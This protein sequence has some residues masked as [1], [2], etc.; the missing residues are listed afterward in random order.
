MMRIITTVGTSLFENYQSNNKNDYDFKDCYQEFKDKSDNFQILLNSDSDSEYQ[1]D[2]E[3]LLKPIKSWFLNQKDAS[4][5]IAS[6]LAIAGSETDIHVHLI[7]TDTVLSVL[8]AELIRDWLNES[9]YNITSYFT[10]PEKLKTQADSK[11]IIHQLRVSS[12]KDFQEGFMNL[13]EVTS[14]LIDE[15]KEDKEEVVLNITGGY[16]AII[17][18]MTLIG[19]IKKVPLKYIYEE[20]DLNKKTELVEVGNLPMNFDWAV[21]EGLR[22]YLS[23]TI[24]VDS[25]GSRSQTVI[26]QLTRLHLIKKELNDYKVTS[27]GNLLVDAFHNSA[28]DNRILGT[29]VEYKYLEYFIRIDNGTNCSVADYELEYTYKYDIDKETFVFDFE[30]DK[31]TLK[32]KAGDID[33]FLPKSKTIIEAKNFFT[34][35]KYLNSQG[36]YKIEKKDKVTED[37]YKQLKAKI[38]AFHFKEKKYPARVLFLV[39]AILFEK[40]NKDY[41]KDKDL[42]SSLSYFKRKLEQDYC[43]DEKPVIMFEA[44]LCKFSFIKEKNLTVNYSHLLSKKLLEKDFSVIDLE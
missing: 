29:F 3:Y 28:L 27:L 37:Y 22:V 42:I 23:N 7:A 34:A 31:Y 36:C 14:K 24:D 35:K 6:I 13:I 33:L 18:I 25:F 26:N 9:E 4:A 32:A 8:A 10:R 20:S 12:N 17:P 30:E 16:K 44:K 11:H 39:N 15:C 2:I 21:M 5:E 41:S 19:Q 1:E 40:D 38:E 43:A